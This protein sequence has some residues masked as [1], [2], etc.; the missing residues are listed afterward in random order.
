V[1][2]ALPWL[3]LAAIGCAATVPRR[4][5]VEQDLDDTYRYRR[6]Q[7]VLDVEVPVTGNAAEGHTAVYERAHDAEGP[8]LAV[9]FVARY[10]KARGLAM[11]LCRAVG[12][13]EG[14]DARM[15]E[16]GGG[17]AWVLAGEEGDRWAIWASTRYI[18]KVGT[19]DGRALPEDL[20]ERYMDVY[21]SE[22]GDDG[23][24]EPGAASAGVASPEAAP[25]PPETPTPQ[26]LQ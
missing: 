17:N 23:R 5:V 8:A 2:I 11:E 3:A 1:A 22:L 7:K 21:P 10:A 12:R 4:Y 9:A 26:F 6:Y 15:R 20:V 18:V 24:P 16:V 19:P 25:P 14:Y 13:L